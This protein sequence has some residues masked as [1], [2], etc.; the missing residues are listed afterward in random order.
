MY[1]DDYL[2]V[3]V[4][5][6]LRGICF[7]G[8]WLFCVCR[9]HLIDDLENHAVDKVMAPLFT[10]VNILSEAEFCSCWFMFSVK[11]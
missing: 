8:F 4:K 1:F 6:I 7:F 2:G 9:L 3:S 5:K 11:Y 10:N